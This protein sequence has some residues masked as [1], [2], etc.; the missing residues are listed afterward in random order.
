MKA[1]QGQIFLPDGNICRLER[2]LFRQQQGGS[3]SGISLSVQIDSIFRTLV[4]RRKFSRHLMYNCNW[5]S[6]KLGSKFQLVTTQKVTKIEIV[7]MTIFVHSKF[8][9]LKKRET[10]SRLCSAFYSVSKIQ[11]LDSEMRDKVR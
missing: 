6:Q 9:S 10:N 5:Q 7:E 3:Y 2:V 11:I 1:S 4:I 8:L